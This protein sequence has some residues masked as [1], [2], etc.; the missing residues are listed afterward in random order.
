M[1]EE[2]LFI[3]Y[4][5]CGEVRTSVCMLYVLDY[6]CF[7]RNITCSAHIASNSNDRMQIK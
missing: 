7:V 4:S 2:I 1:Q 6:D 5:P 3:F